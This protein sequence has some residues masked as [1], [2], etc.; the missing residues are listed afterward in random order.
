[1][2]KVL[3][4]LNCIFRNLSEKLMQQLWYF[5]TSVF[6]KKQ[7]IKKGQSA[8]VTDSGAKSEARR[9]QKVKIKRKKQYIISY[10]DRTATP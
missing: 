9:G 5:C 6:I 2:A 1:M 10:S 4:E 7:T 3:I 8:G